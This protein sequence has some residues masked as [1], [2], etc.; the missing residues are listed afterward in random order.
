[1]DFSDPGNN[2]MDFGFG[3]SLIHDTHDTFLLMVVSVLGIFFNEIISFFT[4]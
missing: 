1:M 2:G 4:H 3:F